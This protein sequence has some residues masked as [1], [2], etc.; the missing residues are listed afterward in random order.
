[1]KLKYVHYNISRGEAVPHIS[2]IR[3]CIIII[4]TGTLLHTSNTIAARVKSQAVDQ[5]KWSGAL[6][7]G[8]VHHCNSK[9]IG[10]MI[11]MKKYQFL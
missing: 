11:E 9:S 7:R 5:D 4:R 1:M 2:S 3:G 8:I 6:K 10:D